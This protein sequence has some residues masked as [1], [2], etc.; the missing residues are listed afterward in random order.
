MQEARLTVPAIKQF[1]GETGLRFLGFE[2]DTGTQ[3]R[4]HTRFRQSGWAFT[5]LDRWHALETAEPNLFAG[6]YQF[7]VQKS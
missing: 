3:Q 4:L 5:D 2:F 1:L 6:M 7:W